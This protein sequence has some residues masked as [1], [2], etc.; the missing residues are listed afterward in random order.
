[1][2]WLFC[3][4]NC[5]QTEFG[6]NWNFI[7]WTA[8]EWRDLLIALSLFTTLSVSL[9]VFRFVFRQRKLTCACTAA[10]ASVFRIASKRNDCFKCVSRKKTEHNLNQSCYHGNSVLALLC[11]CQKDV[12]WLNTINE[13]NPI[14]WSTNKVAAETCGCFCQRDTEK[15]M[16]CIVWG[17]VS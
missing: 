6:P 14:Q 1:M 17:T 15:K 7:N 4:H 8:P 16:L 10:E 12:C 11:A 13:N 5:F 2:V 9:F 3:F